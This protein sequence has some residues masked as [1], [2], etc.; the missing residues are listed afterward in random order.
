MLLAKG[1]RIKIRHQ[2]SHIELQLTIDDDLS[3][4]IFFLY[5][6]VCKFHYNF[7]LKCIEKKFKS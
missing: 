6:L 7:N 2:T 1:R 4:N 5:L 3:Q